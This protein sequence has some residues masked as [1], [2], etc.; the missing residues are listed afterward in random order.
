[1]L[2]PL[3][4]ELLQLGFFLACVLSPY[5][6]VAVYYLCRLQ[7]TGLRRFLLRKLLGPSSSEGPKKHD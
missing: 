5:M 1:V 6:Y 4:L 3:G 7:V 2:V